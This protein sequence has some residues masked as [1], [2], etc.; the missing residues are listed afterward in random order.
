[1]FRIQVI[2]KPI[3]APPWACICHTGT[4]ACDELV[5]MHV[6]CK[7]N[8]VVGWCSP[9]FAYNRQLLIVVYVFIYH[10]GIG[11]LGCARNRNRAVCVK[12]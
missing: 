5:P 6:K 3:A 12:I 9:I 7:R 10:F 11:N 1:M 4:N 2:Y 8:Q